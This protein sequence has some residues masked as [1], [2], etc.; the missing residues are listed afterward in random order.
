VSYAALV[1]DRFDDMVRFYGSTLNFPRLEGWDPQNG[2][3]QR[4]DLDELLL[5]IL[6]NGESAAPRGVMQQDLID[7]KRDLAPG[8]HVA[9]D[10]VVRDELVRQL[11]GMIGAPQRGG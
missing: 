2:R 1:T 5:E 11:L 7:R 8:M 6:D 3:W 9:R 4:F 10:E